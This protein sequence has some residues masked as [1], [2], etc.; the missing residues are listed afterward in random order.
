MIGRNLAHQERQDDHAWTN[1]AA[2]RPVPRCARPLGGPSASVTAGHFLALFPLVTDSTTA[3]TPARI[4][5]GRSGQAAAMAV[6]SGSASAGPVQTGVQTLSGPSRNG[7][8][9]SGL[10]I[11]VNGFVNRRLAVRGRPVAVPFLGS[12]TRVLPCGGL[13]GSGESRKC[14]PSLHGRSP[15]HA[16][17]RP[18]A[19]SRWPP[20]R[21]AHSSASSSRLDCA[22]PCCGPGAAALLPPASS[23]RLSSA[24]RGNRPPGY[25][26]TGSR[27]GVFGSD[28]KGARPGQGAAALSDC[29][30]Q[31]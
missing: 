10:S 9:P 6:T 17:L 2:C 25:R 30:K 8:S 12:K 3:R 5:S 16:P 21:F 20:G 27:C 26:P 1:E 29:V 22:Q 18:G 24:G 31:R 13:P 7:L 15:A 4:G 19:H 11:W 14:A 28:R 23:Q